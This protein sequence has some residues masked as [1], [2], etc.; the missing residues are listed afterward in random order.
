MLK[1]ADALVATGMPH[2]AAALVE[3]HLELT[4]DGEPDAMRARLHAYV[5]HTFSLYDNDEDWRSHLDAA[6]A[7]TPEEPT[8]TGPGCWRSTPGCCG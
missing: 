2:R 8:P 7:L 4:T 5:A 3:K 1:T 6:R